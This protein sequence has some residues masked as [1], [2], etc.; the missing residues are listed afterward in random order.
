[1][2][3]EAGKTYVMASGDIVFIHCKKN[4]QDKFTFIGE[5][6]GGRLECFTEDGKFSINDSTH[7]FNIISEYQEKLC[8]TFEVDCPEYLKYLEIEEIE[9]AIRSVIDSGYSYSLSNG[10]SL[11]PLKFSNL[12][13]DSDFKITL[14]DK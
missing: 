10:Y 14:L 7:K 8:I 6:E 2:K 11:T 12:F 3:I 13:K 4:N 1:M 9:E 5:F